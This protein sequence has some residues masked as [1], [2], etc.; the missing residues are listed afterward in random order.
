MPHS[1]SAYFRPVTRLQVQLPNQFRRALAYRR[2]HIVK[3]AA[4]GWHE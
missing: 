2:W 4:L 1:P 3:L